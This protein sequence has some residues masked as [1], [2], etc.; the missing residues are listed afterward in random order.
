MDNQEHSLVRR[1]RSIWGCFHHLWEFHILPHR[2]LAGG[3]ADT[4]L[5]VWCI[6]QR[7]RTRKSSHSKCC[8]LDTSHWACSGIFRVVFNHHKTHVF[9]VGWVGSLDFIL[10]AAVAVCYRIQLSQVSPKQLIFPPKQARKQVLL[11]V[12]LPAQSPNGSPWFLA[13]TDAC[14]SSP[15]LNG[16]TCVD[17]ID[18]FKCFCLPS[19]GGDLCEIGTA[20]LASANPT[21]CCTTLFPCYPPQKTDPQCS[22]QCCP[23]LSKLTSNS[24]LKHTREKLWGFCTSI[25]ISLFLTALCRL[26]F[27]SRSFWCLLQISLF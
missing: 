12:E 14:H 21:N 15:C 1:Q 27:L 9:L 2:P 3:D 16:A 23:H 5:H 22:H 24:S 6:R 25:W 17:G 20:S 8:V 13:D 26:R 7:Q 18:S 11:L 4:S 10:P 19:Y